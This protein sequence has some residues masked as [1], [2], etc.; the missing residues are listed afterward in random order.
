MKLHYLWSIDPGYFHLKRAT[1]TVVGILITLCLVRKEDLLTQMMACLATGFSMQGIVAK[2][3][4]S[5]VKQVLVLDITYFVVFNLGL[6][7]RESLGLRALLLVVV[8]FFAN[9]MRRFGL[10]NSVAPMMGWTIC[11]FATTLPFSSA[12]DAWQHI[13]A[14]A[15][16]LSISALMILLIFPE[17]YPKLFISNTNRLFVLMA[18]GMHALR[19]ENLV[20]NQHQ[21]NDASLGN[22]AKQLTKI[23]ESN[24]AIEQSNVFA[25]EALNTSNLLIH[26][27]ALV[28]V[29]NMILDAYRILNRHEQQLSPSIRLMLN[30]KY[31]QFELMLCALCMQEDGFVYSDHPKPVSFFNI[32]SL[33]SELTNPVMILVILN[34]KLSFILFEKHMRLLVR[35]KDAA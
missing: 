3:F 17:D 4:S 8:G 26:Q 23:L 33:S 5:R 25:D 15:L 28:H 34:L 19:R 2:A 9:Y 24:Q 16:G 18:E 31:K 10:Q 27:Y 29:F 21:L 7:V 22:I 30:R 12:I 32:Q 11:F 13:D 35:D 1:K 6:L 20:M 14:L